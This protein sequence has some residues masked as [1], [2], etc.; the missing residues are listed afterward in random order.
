MNSS[1]HIKEKISKAIR[2]IGILK[3]LYNVLPKN[4]LIT[5]YKSFIWPH[6]GYG[7]II[8]DYPENES[9]YKEIE[10]V[11][12]NTALAIIGV[13]QGTLREKL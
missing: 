11:Q 7:A 8:F 13:I 10:S 4:S 12:Y 5:I 9:F 6:L 3:K 2:G 1:N